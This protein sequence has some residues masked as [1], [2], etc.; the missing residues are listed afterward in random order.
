MSSQ[1]ADVAAAIKNVLE[2]KLQQVIDKL[3]GILDAEVAE[4]KA[5]IAL[6]TK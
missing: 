6:S 5:T 1:P 4:F 3:L 2:G